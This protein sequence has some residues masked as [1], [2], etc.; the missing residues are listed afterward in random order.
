MSSFEMGEQCT[1]RISLVLKYDSPRSCRLILLGLSKLHSSAL[2]ICSLMRCM[3]GIP[4]NCALPFVVLTILHSSLP[5][6]NSYEDACVIIS[7]LNPSITICV[8]WN[9]MFYEDL[10]TDTLWIYIYYRPRNCCIIKDTRL[11]ESNDEADI[12]KRN[13]ICHKW[14]MELLRV[15]QYLRI[16]DRSQCIKT[17]STKLQETVINILGSK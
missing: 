10:L 14:K 6:V 4:Y 13:I 11:I 5:L 8:W 3:L 1:I 2:R 17:R 15:I 12:M 16:K 9:E 7:E